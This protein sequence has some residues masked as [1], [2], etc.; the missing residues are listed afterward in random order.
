MLFLMKKSEIATKSAPVTD[1]GRYVVPA[2]ER[3]FDILE[4]L[5]KFPE[6]LTQSELARETGLSVNHLFRMMATL[7]RRRLVLRFGGD[8]RY[9]VTTRL[10]QLALEAPPSEQM[11]EAALPL[12]RALAAKVLQSCHLGIRSEDDLLIVAE[13]PAPKR[14]RL[15]VRLGAQFSLA[16]TT[17]GLVL[18]AHEP[19]EALVKWLAELDEAQRKLA[20]RR[21]VPHLLSAIAKRG[22]LREPS[23]HISGVMNISAPIFNHAGQCLAALTAIC[24]EDREVAIGI[25]AVQQSLLATAHEISANLGYRPDG[26]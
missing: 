3:A 20:H 11:L 26:H 19:A 10:L 22:Y 1:E 23:P 16:S 15:T 6:G 12:M 25:S 13:Y 18:L 21:G 4:T 5:V 9:R 17:S 7:E 24:Q 14:I 8:G 2:V